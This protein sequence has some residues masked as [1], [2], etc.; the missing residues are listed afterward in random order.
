M[1][2]AW[3]TTLSGWSNLICRSPPLLETLNL[4][5][6]FALSL[7]RYFSIAARSAAA[8]SRSAS[9]FTSRSASSFTSR[10]AFSLLCCFVCRAAICAS[11][12]D[13]ASQNMYSNRA[14]EGVALKMGLKPH[15][16]QVRG[17]VIFLQRTTLRGVVFKF[18]P[19]SARATAIAHR[20]RDR[21]AAP[22]DGI[23]LERAPR[24]DR[25]S[26]KSISR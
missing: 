6:G 24:A 8:T 10:S 16:I 13:L 15:R 4:T 19:R 9:S 2:S 18:F 23:F 21:S 3:P 22:A 26:E 5:N 1:T 7:A 25:R 20:I 12:R 14:S 17:S 11:P